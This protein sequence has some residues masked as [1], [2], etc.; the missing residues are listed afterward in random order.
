MEWRAAEVAYSRGYGLWAYVSAARHRRRVDKNTPDDTQRNCDIH[1]HDLVTGASP[2]LG[3]VLFWGNR[4]EAMINEAEPHRAD[5]EAKRARPRPHLDDVAS[6]FHG[7]HVCEPC[8]VGSQN[9]A[10]PCK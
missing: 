5:D 4:S 3:C 1:F 9:D 8:T 7:D 6:P 10:T 2:L